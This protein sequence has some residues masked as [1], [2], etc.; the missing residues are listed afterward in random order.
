GREVL[1]RVRA[2]AG[3]MNHPGTLERAGETLRAGWTLEGATLVVTA[4][5][6]VPEAIRLR[7]V[8]GVGGDDSSLRLRLGEER[9]TLSRLGAEGA[10]LLAEVWRLWLPERADALRLAAAGDSVRFSGA[11]ARGDAAPRPCQ[12]QLHDDA[13]L[14]AAEDADIEP[15]FLARLEDIAFD[16]ASMTVQLRDWDGDVLRLAKLAGRTDE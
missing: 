11:M 9:L 12:A 13:L 10:N 15:V 2:A 3:R 16:A 1:P 4:E 8:A 6:R 14:L 7:E 5:G